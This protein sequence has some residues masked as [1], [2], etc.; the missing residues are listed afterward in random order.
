MKELLEMLKPLVQE[1]SKC[2]ST[3]NDTSEHYGASGPS[4]GGCDD[5][6]WEILELLDK[7]LA[8]NE[9]QS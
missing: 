6:M 9:N 2:D 3:P 8:I 7:Y 4:C 5:R 1:N